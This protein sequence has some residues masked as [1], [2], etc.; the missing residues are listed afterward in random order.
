MTVEHVGICRACF[1]PIRK[2][3]EMS[4]N[5]DE[6]YFHKKC[7]DERP[8]A[9][10]VALERIKRDYKSNKKNGTDLMN[11]MEEIFNIPALNDPDFNEENK[12]VISLYRK[13]SKERSI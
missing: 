11:E 13:I 9:Y 2:G 3:Q 8:R 10:Y 7:A 6:L 12:D 4:F 1:E 5:D